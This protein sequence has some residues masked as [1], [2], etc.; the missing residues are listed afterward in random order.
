MGKFDDANVFFTS[1]VP[2]QLISIDQIT[3]AKTVVWKNPKPS[4]PRFCRPLRIQFLHETTG[5]TV[6]E[7]DNIKEQVDI[8]VLLKKIVDEKEISVSHQLALTI[9]DGK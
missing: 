9:L 8:L 6:T 4:F 5:A 3:N 2:L 7:V 1:L